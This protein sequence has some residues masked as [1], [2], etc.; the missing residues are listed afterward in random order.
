M[1]G[2]A[3]VFGGISTYVFQILAFRQLGPEEYAAF[4]GLWI[5]AFVLAP[6][7]FTPFE[8][9][10]A[11]GIAHRRAQGRG[12]SPLIV[13][14]LVVYTCLTVVVVSLILVLRVPIETRLLRSYDELIYVLIVFLVGY[15]LASVGR[16]VLSGHAIFARYAFTSMSESTTRVAA[17]VVLGVVGFGTLGWFGLVF[18]AGPYVAALV[19]AV[20]ARGFVRGGPPASIRDLSQAVGWLLVSSLLV[21]ALS[22]SAYIGVAFL[23]TPEQNA[24]LGVFVAG[25]FLA[26][27]PL[28]VFQMAQTATLPTLA[29]L[30]GSGNKRRFQSRLVQFTLI[31]CGLSGFGIILALTL[32]A[33]VGRLIFGSE[34]TLSG[35]QLASLTTGIC[36]MGIAMTLGQGLVAM[37]RYPATVFAWATGTFAYF[38]LIVALPF[39]PFARSTSAFVAGSFVAVV[40]MAAC[41]ARA[42]R[43]SST[44]HS[45]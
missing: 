32:G 2:I 21:Q 31:V 23:A 25:L 35:V 13:K 30:L 38:A 37:R 36:L 9:E 7:I 33:T 18:A 4:N 16:G 12:A 43:N 22:Y 39:D 27:V 34:F 26:R 29:A 8:Q 14:A 17:A 15:G 44:P 42:L 24:E 3:L 40:V 5:V 41:V 20:L 6:G 1:L 28:L 19:S 11:R 10:L 45:A